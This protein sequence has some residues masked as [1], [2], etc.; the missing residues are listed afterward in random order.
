[1][2]LHILNNGALVLGKENPVLIDGDREGAHNRIPV[3]SF[4]L[5]TSAGYVLFDCACDD[6]GMS[7]WPQWLKETP[8]EPGEKGTLLESLQ[9]IGVSPEE[10]RYVVLSHMHVD[11][12]G[13]LK[14]FPNAR[15]LVN[16]REFIQVM[17]NYG[18]DKLGGTFHVK[19]DIENSLRAG[20]QWQLIYD[21][22]FSLC[23]EVTVYNLGPGHSYGMLALLVKGRQG[24]YILASDAVYSRSH[25]GPPAQMAGVCMDEEGYYQAIEK[26]RTIAETYEAEVFFGHDME[27]FMRLMKRYEEGEL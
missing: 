19:T 3:H 22:T 24:N 23:H 15:T 26:I 27:Q 8:Y 2:K 18:E 9:A 6:Q 5:D 17:K 7:V 21:E 4:L 12:M 16:A 10:I 25:Y 14:Y 13:C 1:M 20:I 11:H